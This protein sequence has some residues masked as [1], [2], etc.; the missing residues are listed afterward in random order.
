[1]TDAEL[2]LIAAE[3]LISEIQRL[4]LL[5]EQVWHEQ[6]GDSYYPAGK[7]STAILQQ[8]LTGNK[9]IALNLVSTAGLTRTLVIDFDGVPHGKGEQH[10]DK[11]CEV[12]NGLQTELGLPAP[13]V[14]VSGRKGYGLWISL[15]Q[16]IPAATAQSFLHLIR[17][18]YLAGVEAIDLRPD[19]DKPTD[20]AQAVAKLPP[21]LHRASGKWAAFI[22]PEVG[23]IFSETPYLESPANL[24]AQAKLLAGIESASLM[25]IMQA[26]TKLQQMVGGGSKKS[27]GPKLI[28]IYA[29]ASK[30]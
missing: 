12:A 1:M 22:T 3:T 9:T 23:A 19:T 2:Q 24:T 18:K 6:K 17:K 11:L 4:F 16:P 13:A 27:E 28:P 30:G 26:I 7:L 20:A 14:S 21:C 5:P 8:H 15:E 10:W 29:S 25:Q